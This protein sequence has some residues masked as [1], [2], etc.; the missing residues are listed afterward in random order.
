MRT[1]GL[2][3]PVRAKA[4]ARASVQQVA[5]AIVLP[6][7]IPMS[8]WGL[9][10][11]SDGRLV[12]GG[13]ALEELLARFGSPL[14]VV[15][16]E[17][18]EA[19]ARRFTAHPTGA[20]RPCDVFYS[21][22]T[23]PV[24]GVLKLLH[25]R[26]VGAEAT[27]PYELWLAMR[28]GVEPEHIIYNEPAKGEA[29]MREVIGAG[30]G[31]TNLNAVQEIAPFAAMARQLKRRPRVGLRVCLPGATGGQFGERVDDGS[32]LRAFA[33]ALR[34]PELEVIAV[35]AHLNSEISGAG[36]LRTFLQRLFAFADTLYT[37]LK[38]EV[39]VLD[40]GGNL[41]CP[42]ISHR[43]PLARRFALATG[44]DVS[45]EQF[46]AL[47]ID[48]YVREISVE[49]DAH[50]AK[51]GRRRPRIYVEP[52][53]AMTASTQVLLSR[54]AQVRGEDASGITTAVLDAGINIAEALR[55]ERHQIFALR[56]RAERPRRL[57]RL[58]GPTCTLGDVMAPGCELGALE[59]G[60]ALAFMDAGA[61]CVPFSTSFSFPRPAVVAAHAGQVH[62]LRRAE[63]FEDIVSLDDD[64]DP[65]AAL[66]HTAA[67]ATPPA[68]TSMTASVSTRP[69]RRT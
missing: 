11:G 34:H 19:N 64:G 36:Q 2:P 58:T 8:A 51:A 56:E 5:R 21:Y 42:T 6:S 15:D 33:V 31:L 32:A 65:F 50:F 68:S 52:G 38:L 48:A 66:Q 25:Q 17:R 16:V 47:G 7:G 44:V 46:E 62:L 63:T 10:R 27:S 54:V 49:A 24:P 9:T 30:V 4:W 55:N 1:E 22:K 18:L 14:H 57:Y 3:L 20:S 39:Q 60:D 40:L 28:L 41:S 13:C 59:A 23:N 67:P 45:L 26:G 35:H 53:R 61:Y 69:L 12:L 43:G 29:S 37:H